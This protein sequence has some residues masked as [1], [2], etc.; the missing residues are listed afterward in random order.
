M[1]SVATCDNRLIGGGEADNIEGAWRQRT[2]EAGAGN[3]SYFFNGGNLG[4]D[5]I[6]EAANADDFDTLNFAGFATGVTVDLTKFGSAYAVNSADLKLKLSN[7]TAIENVWGSIFDDTVTGNSRANYLWGLSGYDT[8]RGGAGADFLYGGNGDDILFTDALDQA[9]GGTGTDM[10]DRNSEG[11]ILYRTNPQPGRYMDW[12]NV[13][14]V[15]QLEAVPK[16][17]A[18][19]AP[20]VPAPV[21]PHP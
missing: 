6:N 8:I 17:P 12:G 21:V 1:S 7:D 19:D 5:T 18:T 15:Y 16:M 3:D 11:S 14:D 4:T 10:F 13:S 9:Y 20:S 2:L